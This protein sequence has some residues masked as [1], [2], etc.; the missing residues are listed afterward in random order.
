MGR[1]RWIVWPSKVHIVD[2]GYQEQMLDKMHT[3]L[4]SNATAVVYLDTDTVLAQEITREQ[5]FDE[6]DRPYLCYRST[7]ICG[8]DCKVWMENFVRPMLGEGEML[9]HE[10]MCRLGQ[11]YPMTVFKA[12]RDAVA[13][14]KGERWE[15]FVRDALT[16]A[17]AQS[18]TEKDPAEGF[19]EFNCMGAVLWRDYHEHVH[20]V[21]IDWME[22]GFRTCPQQTWSWETDEGNL[23]KAH[24]MFKCLEKTLHDQPL[25]TPFECN[26][27]RSKCQAQ[28]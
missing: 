8:K 10:Y 9:H 14:H 5:L 4:Y 25:D 21:R 20:W 7:D 16:P 18:W 13:S 26:K 28:R 27:R 15:S 12:M 24:G 1:S 6:N 19:T 23:K 22:M 17:G 11:A 3:D 2:N